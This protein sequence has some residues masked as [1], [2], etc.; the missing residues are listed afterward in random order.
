MPAAAASVLGYGAPVVI[1]GGGYDSC[2]D[3][4]TPTPN[5][6]VPPATARPCTKGGGVYVLD[7]Q[8]GTQLAFFDTNVRDSNGAVIAPAR[9]V[10]AD[11]ALIS[12]AGAGTVD[13]A[14]AADTGGNIWRIDFNANRAQWVMNRV[15]YTNGAGR[16]FLFPPALLAAPGGQVYVALGSGDREHPLQAQYPYT[17]VLNRFYVFKDNLAPTTGALNLDDTTQ[18]DDFTYSSGDQGP[19]GATN[20]TACG[21]PGVLPASPMR[22]W[23]MNLNQNGQG[24]QTVTSAI[25]AAGMV[26][27]N[28]NRP[29]PK[30]QGTCATMLGAAY[31]YWV[32]LFNA[33]G[34]ISPTGQAC[35]GLRDSPFVGAGLPPSP[36]MASV[37]V[38]GQV[39]QT[40]IGAAQLSGGASCGIC[41]QQVKPAIVPTRKTIF[42]KGSGEN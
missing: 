8:S 25:I 21:T 22:G 1:V 5:V 38:N 6:P 17:T 20:G 34:G 13:H 31:G 14:Y 39:V 4:N 7:A 23:F 26:A 41:P 2:E 15:A 40:V 18:M 37:P 42:W 10:T 9:S 30:T 35:G 24:E 3:L 19:N 32:N 27:F 29:V 28:T 16:K 36:V 11:V 12:V 33:S